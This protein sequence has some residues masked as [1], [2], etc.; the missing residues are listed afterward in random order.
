MNTIVIVNS[1]INGTVTTNEFSNVAEAKRLFDKHVADDLPA[2]MALKSVPANITL[3]AHRWSVKTEVTFAEADTRS[4]I[5]RRLIQA[6]VDAA[7]TETIL[8][9]EL[10]NIIN[11]VIAKDDTA[12][13]ALKGIGSK[14]AEKVIDALHGHVTYGA[15]VIGNVRKQFH[16]RVRVTLNR[17]FLQGDDRPWIFDSVRKRWSPLESFAAAI[18]GDEHC[19]INVISTIPELSAPVFDIAARERA[20]Q[21]MDIWDQVCHEGLI[22]NGRK[23]VFIGHGTN[24]AKE[25]STLFCRAEYAEQICKEFAKGVNPGW[26]ITD[27]KYTAYMFGL[28][29]VYA[30]NVGLPIQPED[31]E[32]FGSLVQ[33]IHDNIARNHADG[34]VTFEKNSVVSQNQFDGFSIM[35]VSAK[36]Q[37]VMIERLVSRG[38]SREEA[39]RTINHELAILR[40][41]TV[42]VANAAIK[43]AVY[44]NFDIHSFLHDR[45]VHTV[46]GRDIDDIVMFSDETVLKTAIGPDKAYASKDE[47]C[48]AVRKG[49]E[50][51]KLL[52]EHDLKKKDV[53]Y[54]VIQ[55]AHKADPETVKAFA[56]EQADELNAMH[57]LGEAKRCLTKE[58]QVLIDFMPEAANTKYFANRMKSGFFNKLDDAFGGK[59][60]GKCFG[61]LLAPDVIAFAEHVG[62]LEVKGFLNAGETCCFKLSNGEFAFWRNP[63]LDTGALRVLNN[64]KKVPEAIRKYFEYDT[65]MMMLSIKDTTITRVRGDFDGDKGSVSKDAHLIA[66]FKEAHKNFGDWLTDWDDLGGAK[67]LVTR[68]TQLDYASTLCRESTL[69]QTCCGLNKMYAGKRLLDNGKIVHFDVDYAE[70]S[71]FTTLANNLV[72]AGKH[73]KKS[74]KQMESAAKK[75]RKTKE[76]EALHP[77]AKNYRD[78]HDAM[79]KALAE[80]A[81]RTELDKL[82]V[83]TQP[84]FGT[85]DIYTG[86]LIDNVDRT[87][88]IDNIPAEKFDVSKILYNPEM[89]MRG[90]TG[91]CRKGEV[92]V[93]ELGYRVDEGLFQ[94]IC[95]RT[96]RDWEI[97]SNENPDDTDRNMDEDSFF[98]NCRV[99]ALAELN[100]FAEACGASMTDVFDVIT[101]WVFTKAESVYRN[102]GSPKGAAMD[103][104]FDQVNRGYWMIFGGMMQDRIE[105]LLADSID[106]NYIDVAI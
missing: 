99:Q 47:W 67:G 45:G 37:N 11:A 48:N 26:K 34:T 98:A 89:G 106:M 82:A 55:T 102:D 14:T 40:G 75:I 61:M 46:H 9:M 18:S 8:S 76:S 35:H 57:T 93:E 29:A 44:T 6:G 92:Y 68:E 1:I 27:A 30:E 58:Q 71:N 69:G 32:F 36:M 31:F 59:R 83:S 65:S 10:K 81:P 33:D 24:A 5:R 80:G 52:C 88:H 15:V 50:Y 97:V 4:D 49:F 95:R 38:I 56:R 16:Q 7:K 3:D 2:K 87:F 85:L 43:G 70:V 90:L 39:I 20:E 28:Q 74:F 73:G 21:K 72:D 25:N 86:E 51:K 19:I 94:S 103:I 13:T 23:Y 96:A 105:E 78:L 64:I 53:P 22:L 101:R 60:V 54:Q 77:V 12:F 17:N 104:L 41:H 62:G 42:R 84:R 91:L 79:A 66:M 63:V 100:A